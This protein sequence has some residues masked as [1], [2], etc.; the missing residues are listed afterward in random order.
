MPT[1]FN[2]HSLPCST[3]LSVTKHAY[4]EAESLAQS[5]IAAS[6]QLTK[7]IVEPVKLHTRDMAV[8]QKRVR[9]S[10]L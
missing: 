5:R 6:E 9:L 3:V 2:A 1:R 7:T 8:H 10:L 4:T